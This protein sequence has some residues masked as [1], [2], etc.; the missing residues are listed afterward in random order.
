MICTIAGLTGHVHESEK[1]MLWE[2]EE[3]FDAGFKTLLGQ[4]KL[5][6]LPNPQ[7]PVTTAL[8]GFTNHLRTVYVDLKLRIPGLLPH[9]QCATRACT[10]QLGHCTLEPSA[11]FLILVKNSHTLLAHAEAHG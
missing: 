5:D 6:T 10:C 2:R 3:V 7:G 1:Q 9:D 4:S 11:P 8:Q